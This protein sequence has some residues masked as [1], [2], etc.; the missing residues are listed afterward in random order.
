MQE[1]RM[2][3]FT[4]EQFFEVFTAYNQ[5]VWPAQILLVLLAIIA[6]WY[7]VKARPHAS[8]L[9]AFVLAL[10]W[11]WT[12]AVYLLGFLA[13][14]NPAAYVFAVLFLIQ[15]ALFIRAGMQ[16][17]LSGRKNRDGYGLAGA[18]L[19]LYALFIYPAVGLAA[20]HAYPAAPTFGAP[21][22]VTIFT[23]GL[24]LICER[25]VPGYLLIVPFLWALGGASAIWLFGVVE[26]AV[27][28][29]A[30]ILGSLLILHR[31]RSISRQTESAFRPALHEL[32]R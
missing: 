24:L 27:L 30:G 8:R 7:A 13:P 28:P 14:V 32:R 25:R 29:I 1:L 4:R 17:R 11:L 12:A 6:T 3:A 19:V 15:A 18:I 26:D 23:F 10:L 9:V 31:N 21:C 20:G 2:S 22:P 5:A 16:R